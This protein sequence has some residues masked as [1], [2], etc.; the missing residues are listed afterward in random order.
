MNA[1]TLVESAEEELHCAQNY[2]EMLAKRHGAGK[3]GQAKEGISPR[4]KTEI[5]EGVLDQA[6]ITQEMKKM[7]ETR[8]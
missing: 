4:P 6:T 8:E 2:M 1:V 3:K 5:K 7:E